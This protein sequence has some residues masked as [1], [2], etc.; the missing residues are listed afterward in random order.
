MSIKRGVF[1]TV[2]SPA[3]SDKEDLAKDLRKLTRTE[4]LEMLVD[5]TREAD[6]LRAENARLRK[7]LEKCKEDLDK[8]AS[9]SAVLARLEEIIER[10]GSRN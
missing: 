4:L 3:K 10:A 6:R 1:G 2:S 5:E 9:L 8:T 7:E